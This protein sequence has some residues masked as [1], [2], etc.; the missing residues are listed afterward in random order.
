MRQFAGKCAAFLALQTA[1]FALLLVSYD[2]STESNYLAA[3]FEK[4]A[5]LNR[6]PAPRVILVGGSNLAFGIDSERLGDALGIDAVNMGLAAGFGID[7][8]L[9]EIEPELKRGDVVVLSLEYDRFS[10]GYNP[11]NLRQIVE[12]RPE[13]VF[14]LEPNQWNRVLLRGG[15]SIV[16]GIGRR[17]LGLGSALNSGQSDSPAYARSGFNRWGDLTSHHGMKATF[18]GNPLGSDETLRP[19]WIPGETLMRKLRT[20]AENCQRKGVQFVYSCPPQPPNILSFEKETI[21]LIIERL[22]TV[23]NLILL[24]RPENHVYPDALFFDTGYH[25]THEG[26][27]L[28]TLKLIEALRKVIPKR[29]PDGTK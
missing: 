17:A 22:L 20:F 14:Y 10:G 9:N 4:H 13:S 16:G 27:K 1:V 12:Y 24:D 2:R 5:L 6:T 29:R 11:L 3:A 19:D 21:T 15:L 23:P 26:A 18:A 28:R 25:L 7:F 8:M